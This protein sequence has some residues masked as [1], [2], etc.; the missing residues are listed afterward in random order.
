MAQKV[1]HSTAPDFKPSDAQLKVTQIKSTIGAKP[2]HR[3]T[4]RSLGLKRIH[5]T[6]VRQADPATVGMLNAVKHLVK[7]E[8][9]N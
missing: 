6:V 1:Q 3:E 8:E 2:A 7:V 5:H 4:V 9:T